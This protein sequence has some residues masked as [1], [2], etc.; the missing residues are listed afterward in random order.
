MKKIILLVL[1]I[2]QWGLAQTN[3]YDL[4]MVPQKSKAPAP[5]VPLVPYSM[6][7]DGSSEGVYYTE[8]IQYTEV[9]NLDEQFLSG[10]PSTW[11]TQSGVFTT[12]SSIDNP[13]STND[14]A[15]TATTSGYIS[16]PCNQTY[17]FWE[18]DLYKATD[19]SRID[20]AFMADRITQRPG[21]GT[22]YLAHY[23]TITASE[24]LS[25]NR[26]NGTTASSIMATTGTAY[27]QNN[28]YYRIRITR[29]IAGVWTTYI[30]GGSFGNT[31]IPIVVQTGTNPG[32]DLNLL[33]S[34]YFLVSLGVGDRIANIKA[35]DGMG[36]YCMQGNNKI[37][38]YSNSGFETGAPLEWVGYGNHSAFTSTFE[39]KS[40]TTS[41]VMASTG[42]GN[43]FNY[44][45]L[46]TDK[47]TPLCLGDYYTLEVNCRA[48]GIR[49]PNK[50]QDSSFNNP[51]RWS[52]GSGWQVT[53]GS[54]VATAANGTLLGL[55]TLLVNEYFEISFSVTVTSG[56]VYVAAPG[57]QGSTCTTSGTYINRV[58][59]SGASGGVQ[60]TGSNFTGTIDNLIVKKLTQPSLTVVMGDQVKTMSIVSVKYST[61][62]HMGLN[63]KATSG[64]LNQP[65]KIYSSQADSIYLD[66]IQL[67]RFY[68]TTISGWAKLSTTGSRT[69]VSKQLTNQPIGYTIRENNI[70][71]RS[72]GIY[73]ASTS[74][75]LDGNLALNLYS[76][77]Q[78]LSVWNY[79]TAIFKG[80]SI[81]FL[82]NNTVDTTIAN[83]LG[84]FN[85]SQ[86]LTLGKVSYGTG[87]YYS[88]ELGETQLLKN[89]IKSKSTHL[90]EY[91]NGMRTYNSTV[92]MFR[93]DWRG[94]NDATILNDKSVNNVTAT[95]VSLTI[96]DQ[97]ISTYPVT[98]NA[99]SSNPI[100]SGEISVPLN[101][102]TLSTT[103][104]NTNPNLPRYS[105]FNGVTDSSAG[106]PA[107]GAYWMI[108]NYDEYWL[109]S[110]WQLHA[111]TNH[112]SVVK[113]P[114]YDTINATPSV[115]KVAIGYDVDYTNLA[116]TGTPRNEIFW[117][118]DLG[119]F[120]GDVFRYSWYT[121][122]PPG[123]TAEITGEERAM[124][125]HQLWLMKHLQIYGNK[126]AIDAQ[127]Q[128]LTYYRDT[129]SI[130]TWSADVGRWTRW[131]VETR[132]NNTDGGTT[133]W[134]LKKNGV[135]VYT[136]TKANLR[137]GA[138]EWM[139]KWGMYKPGWHEYSTLLDTVYMYIDQI[140]IQNVTDNIT[141]YIMDFGDSTAAHGGGTTGDV[142]QR[143]VTLTWTSY[144]GATS[145]TIYRGI[146]ANPLSA[147][148]I[149]STNLTSYSESFT[150]Q[151]SYY[152][153]IK[154]NNSNFFSQPT[155]ISSY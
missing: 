68:P 110:D 153:W 18:F 86:N 99:L 148:S 70:P 36:L 142:L 72:L 13:F 62:S 121:Y 64:T 3:P 22:I 71:A 95:G 16:I 24:D 40:G 85:T 145:Y 41:L 1:L 75:V 54:G 101:T 28:T 106:Q 119:Q 108:Q 55:D 73:M 81:T 21:T 6:S 12:N 129:T 91:Q 93:V 136:D 56:T 109:T 52:I 69:L 144:P 8:P 102:Y 92:E 30:K 116:Y 58:K 50:I 7:F 79:Y 139:F 83:N 14:N 107:A 149:T 128:N 51:A 27:I 112:M 17:G 147:S 114:K 35:Q 97:L 37:K 9:I 155:V 61:F 150:N 57:G 124:D 131:E 25:L 151:I 43:A 44:I 4:L 10:I 88:G 31:Y 133:Y 126:Y 11:T 90:D 122:L 98:R 105:P 46:P 38:Y 130:G 63:F 67:V 42:A 65:I 26:A 15:L 135:Q 45:S 80:D 20:I 48:T 137:P 123:F 115:L 34:N 78:T 23:F 53:G 47:F 146:N 143:T 152:Y 39:K 60:I 66:D 117:G 33:Y 154:P 19:G 32:T 140:Q 74:G 104:D 96:D 103:Y 113:N 76:P 89:Y 82:L 87:L 132:L 111:K 141:Y 125:I 2:F 94:L 138:S 84:I 134:T 127:M 100:A 77:S 29:S 118:K 5:P 49:G 59:A 120:A